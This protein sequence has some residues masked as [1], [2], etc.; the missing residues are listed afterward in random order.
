MGLSWGG[1]VYPCKSLE[2]SYHPGILLSFS[3]NQIC[4]HIANYTVREFAH[5]IATLVVGGGCLIALCFWC[6][7]TTLES[8]FIPMHLLKDIRFMAVVCI[9]TT[10]A[11]S[12]YAFAIIWPRAVAVL[13]P[14]LS[15]SNAGWLNTA[16]S[17]CFLVGQSSGNV[18]ASFIEPRYV[19]YFAVPAATA[20]VASVAVNPLDMGLTVGLIVPGLL[21]VGISDGLAIAM[22]TM[23]IRDQDEIGTA[24][25][26]S[27]AIRSLGGTIASTVYSVILANRLAE[28]VP[29]LATAAATGSGLPASS[30]PALITALSGTGNTTM[31]PGITPQ[32]LASAGRAY[33]VANSEAYKT[34]FLSTLAFS[35]LSMI[36]LW[37][38]PKLDKRKRLYVS[39]TLDAS[40]AAV[41]DS[42]KA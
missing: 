5:C 41:D 38:V 33:Q 11:M 1:S 15:A 34:V 26:I 40:Q 2:S 20:L 6:A 30:V 4:L 39:R 17:V 42:E 22:S 8:P 23:V 19:L 21:C 14:N 31:V 36:M 27:G 35:G 13:Y 16:T 24:G 28:T 7:F 18:L 32:I 29:P 37:W 9:V 12:Y 10:G 25:G 3:S